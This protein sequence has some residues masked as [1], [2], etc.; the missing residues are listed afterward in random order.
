VTLV[1]D[2]EYADRYF[3]AIGPDTALARLSLAGTDLKDFTEALRQ[4]VHDIENG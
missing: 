3:L 4:A 2:D 1:R